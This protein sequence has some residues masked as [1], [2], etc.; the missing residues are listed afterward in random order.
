MLWW[1]LQDTLSKATHSAQTGVASALGSIQQTL[2]PKSEEK[3]DPEVRD[4]RWSS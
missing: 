2:A 4:F 1:P 3:Q